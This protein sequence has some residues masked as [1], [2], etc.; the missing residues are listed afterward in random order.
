MTHQLRKRRADVHAWRRRHRR[1]GW[2]R[3][4]DRRLGHVDRRGRVQRGV[5]D[6]DLRRQQRQQRPVHRR[7]PARRRVQRNAHLHARGERQRVDDGL[8][9]GQGQRR[10]GKRRRR[11]RARPRRSRSRSTT[12]TTHRRSPTGRPGR[13]R[14]RRHADRVRLGDRHL[15]RP[16]ERER[17]DHHVRRH[18]EH[19]RRVCSRAGRASTRRQADLHSPADDANG[20][21][22][23]GVQV[24]DNGGT[25]N[26]GDDNSPTQTFTSRSTAS[27]TCPRSPGPDATSA[28]DPPVLQIVSTWATDISA[29]P[30]DE[31]GQIAVLRDHGN[32]NPSLFSDPA[33]VNANGDLTFKPVVN[34]TGVANVTVHIH[35]DGGTA[36][37]GVD[38]SA[39]QSF[40][41]DVSRHQRSAD[42][43]QRRRDRPPRGPD[44]DRRLGNDSGG[45][46]ELA[47][48]VTHHLGRRGS[49]GHRH[50]RGTDGR[51]A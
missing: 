49:R 27:T 1:R 12:S 30:A 16:R 47:D 20:T 22:T 41:I 24:I 25:A 3:P 48:P 17:A 40:T 33:V 46:G 35:D 19:Q 11:H 21:A 34:G 7:R 29:G 2:R 5:A 4:H 51:R 6:R 50:D 18:L 8:R 43:R 44:H 39:D 28:E 36:D 26:G 37:G 45:P 9:P 13:G 10:H 32:D 42:R 14:G 15:H 38:T 23:I 31:G